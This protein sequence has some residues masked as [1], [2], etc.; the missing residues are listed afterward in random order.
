MTARC[1]MVLGT[2]SGAG[3]SW[4]TTALCRYYARQGLKVAPFKAQN[5]SNNARVVASE[6][7]QGEVGSAQYFQALAAKAEPD[8]RMNPLLLKPEADTRSQ[9]VLLGE[10]SEALSNTPWRGRSEKVWPQISAALDELI[11][12][13]D[14][15]VIEGA[16]SPAE[17]NLMDSDIVNLRVAQHANARCLLVTDIDRGGAFAHLYGTWA[18]LPCGDQKRIEGFVLNKFRGDASL[19][20]P[21]PQMLQERTGVPVVAT[22]P[23]WWQHGLPEEDGVFDDRTRARG[24]VHKTAAVVAYPRISNLDEF[25][26]LQNVP[27][28]RLLW[29]RTPSDLAGLGPNDWIILPGSKHTSAD[30]RW[31]R[32]QGLDE[33][34]SAHVQQGGAVLGIC[35][36]LQMLGE[37]LIDTHGI[38]GNAPGLGLLPLV[39]QFAER[40]T[41]R[42]TQAA[43]GSLLGPWSALSGVTVQ[44]YEIH[45]GHTQAHPAMLAA[46][47]VLHEVMPDLSWQ[48]AE[49]QV[50]GTYL[51]GL[52]ESPAVLQAL[53]GAR[54]PTLETVFEGLADYIEK[55]FEPSVLAGLLR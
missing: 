1:I 29:A 3:K 54:V 20:A 23:M 53:F 19:L 8:V 55:H 48:S 51:H 41:V 2:S 4:L 42:R 33:A 24:A 44:G 15:V 52:F 11:A 14:V 36:G 31:L 25:Q 49:G 10:V 34:V 46:G 7:G 12:E 50:L 28:L 21:A 18:L 22:L 37:A 27:G 39:T 5:M 45:H 32:Q 40:K 17:I 26:P 35:G 47:N 30:L 16:G 38:D 9:V 13:N 6:S 43:F